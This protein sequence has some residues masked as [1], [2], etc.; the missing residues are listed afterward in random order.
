[1]PPDA[2]LTRRD[3]F[4]GRRADH[5]AMR[6][7]WALPPAAFLDTCTRCSAC[8]AACPQQVLGTGDGGFPQFDPAAGEC[9]FCG[10]CAEACLPRALDPSAVT[11]PWQQP[12]V[13]ADRCFQNHGIV[14]ASCLDACP[15][16]AIGRT[17]GRTAMPIVDPERCSGC[18]ACVAVCPAGAIALAVVAP[19]AIR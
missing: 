5:R 1:M 17:P 19:E 18:G 7:P 2:R 4:L 14:C 10:R 6:P 3:L 8:I 12:A 9:T 11:R 15:K 16:A 13:I